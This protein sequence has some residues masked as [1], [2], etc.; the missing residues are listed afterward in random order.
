MIQILKKALYI[1]PLLV[2]SAFIK[3]EPQTKKE[4]DFL[5]SESRWVDSVFNSLNDEQRLAQLFMVAAYSNK[6]MKHVR[7]IRELIEGNYRIFYRMQKGKI[8]ILRIHNAARKI[9]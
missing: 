1:I 4:P 8:T 2:I 7:E 5:K 9:K 3:P 6:D